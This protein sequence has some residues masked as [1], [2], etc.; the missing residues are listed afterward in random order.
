[1]RKL[2][3]EPIEEGWL[4]SGSIHVTGPSGAARLAVP[5]RGPRARGTLLVAARKREGEWAFERAEVQVGSE[6]LDLLPKTIDVTA[7]RGRIAIPPT[8]SNALS[9][10]DTPNGGER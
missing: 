9:G 2:L 3:G 5:L 7:D 4:F 1:V 8:R 10:S 6:R